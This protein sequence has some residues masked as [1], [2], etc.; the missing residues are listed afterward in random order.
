MIDRRLLRL[1]GKHRLVEVA[2]LHEYATWHCNDMVVDD[3]GRAYVGNLG[4][5]D[6]TDHRIQS[7]VLLRIDPD[8]QICVAA[9]GLINPNGMAITPDGATLLVSETFAGRITAFNRNRDG[10]LHERREWAAFAST[11]FETVPEALASSA[12]LPDGI[13]LD[14][15]GAVWVGDCHGVGATRVAEGGEVLDYVPT[16]NYATFAVALGGTHRRTLY[17]CTAPPYS[18]AGLAPG[19]HGAM[20]SSHVTVPGSGRP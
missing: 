20:C 9:D 14:E 8:G 7:T 5:D 13:A 18:S 15:E 17:M 4:W 3:A 6:E 12:I 2:D 11:S 16:G 1:E 19:L 10:T